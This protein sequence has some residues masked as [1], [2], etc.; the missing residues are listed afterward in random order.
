M[1]KR[2]LVFATLAIVWM[3]II[4]LFSSRTSDVSTNDSNGI[5]LLI[6]KTFVSNFE[7]WNEERQMEFAQ[8]IDHPIRKTAHALEYAL[9]GVLLTGA[10]VDEKNRRKAR[11]LIPW[12]LGTFYAATDEFHQLFVPG[13]SGQVSDVAL[14]SV[15]V[16]LGVLIVIILYSKRTK[17]TKVEK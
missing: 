1:K 15:G 5:G 7:E 8:N 17:N 4:F 12:G 9:L 10:F 14:D 16:L 6:G 2:K 13:R 3:G 11:I